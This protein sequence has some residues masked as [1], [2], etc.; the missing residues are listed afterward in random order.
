MGKPKGREA[1]RF[2]RE[3]RDGVTIWSDPDLRPERTAG[4]VVVRLRRLLWLWPYLDIIA[5]EKSAL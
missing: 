3:E 1:A 4:S 5:A 2:R